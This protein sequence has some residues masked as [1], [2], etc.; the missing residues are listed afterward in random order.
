MA[1]VVV[2]NPIPTAAVELLR[3]KHE[4]VVGDSET[5]QQLPGLLGGADAVLTLIT[6]RVDDAFLDAAGDQL[7]IVANV[8]VGYDNI[9]LAACAR[10]RV[11]VTNTPT[12]LT[13][14]TADLAFCLL[15]MATRRCG[16]GERL[17]RSGEL[18]EWGMDFMLG[19]SVQSRTLGIVGAGQIGR[20]VARRAIA[21]GMN[22]VYS[23]RNE[24]PPDQTEELGARRCG[25]AELLATSD[26]VTLHCPYVPPGQADSTHHLIGASQLA[27][28]KPTAYLINTARGA[29]VDEG[30]LVAALADGTIA[31]A[32]LDVYERE[33]Q[34]H[35]GLLGL[36]NVVLLPH[37]G[38]ATVET[39]TAM[40][41]L[42]AQN[43]LSVLAGRD[44][45]T[46][47]SASAH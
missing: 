7:R 31:G 17:I 21:F 5:A 37:L 4:V 45:V 44:A 46:P 6:D 32:G 28:M 24:L 11:L 13:D 14:A 29:V 2:T 12:V 34:V 35:P 39:R 30:A 43:V 42:A 20:A 47:V 15:L 41:H 25:L 10:R 22:I 27:A 33:P 36:E 1:R 23:A 40:A 18:C 9:D 3:S 26:V 38:S 19:S 8:A 16:E